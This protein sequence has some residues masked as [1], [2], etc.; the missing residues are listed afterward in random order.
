MTMVVGALAVG[1]AGPSTVQADICFF[2][3]TSGIWASASNWSCEGGEDIP[4]S[5]DYASISGG[6][7]CIVDAD[8]NA[9]TLSISGTLNIET[10]KTV[11]LHG[12]GGDIEMF[13]FM[14]GIIN[15]EGS[16][17]VLKLLKSASVGPGAF[18]AG[19]IVGQHNDAKILIA[20]DAT[21]TNMVIIE[22]NLQITEAALEDATFVNEETV[23]A[24]ANGTL[25]I[26]TDVINDVSTA[27]WKVSTSSSAVLKLEPNYGASSP[28]FK[29]DFE[30]ANGTLDIQKTILTEGRL[31]QTGGTLSVASGAAIEFN[32]QPD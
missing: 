31:F 5:D 2:S 24:N 1:V 29:G 4:D 20:D 14:D 12:L 22:G 11:T 7:T 21:F 13:V 8:A 17:S 16:G 27:E 10:G 30:I 25:Y 32:H 18:T 23:H 15:L 19:K 3:P 26:N 28:D 9:G 6:K